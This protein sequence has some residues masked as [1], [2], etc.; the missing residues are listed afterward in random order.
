MM[1]SSKVKDDRAGREGTMQSDAMLPL[2]LGGIDTKL[3]EI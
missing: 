3:G 2:L 1:N